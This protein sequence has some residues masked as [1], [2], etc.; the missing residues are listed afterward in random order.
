ME[1]YEAYRIVRNSEG[2]VQPLW[3]ATTRFLDDA[4]KILGGWAQGYIVDNTGA[5]ITKKGNW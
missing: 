5:M 2:N 4:E 3:L 1:K